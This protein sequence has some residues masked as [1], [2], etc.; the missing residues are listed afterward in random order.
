MDRA[1]DKESIWFCLPADRWA[2]YT[3]TWTSGLNVNWTRFWF[4]APSRTS[5]SCWGDRRRRKSWEEGQQQTTH[6]SSIFA[7]VLPDITDSWS[8]SAANRP[9]YQTGGE[10][11]TEHQLPL[12]VRGCSNT[13]GGVVKKKKQPKNYAVKSKLKLI[14]LL[15]CY[16]FHGG[17]RGA[18][19]QVREG[20]NPGQFFG[21]CLQT[22]RDSHSHHIKT[23][24]LLVAKW[25]VSLNGRK[26][27]HSLRRGN[28]LNGLQQRLPQEVTQ[29]PRM[30]SIMSMQN[31]VTEAIQST[32]AWTK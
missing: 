27:K 14:H 7:S 21:S 23:Y 18:G 13:H 31:L 19:H 6:V 22:Q 29:L 11:S 32:L 4:K 1:Q 26:L 10:Y 12:K 2:A 8:I 30:Y 5:D 24:D 15:L 3:V 25:M 9:I 17:V 20:L 16:P 28:H